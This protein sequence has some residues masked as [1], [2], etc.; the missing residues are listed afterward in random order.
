MTNENHT[1]ISLSYIQFA[2]ILK[3]CS[4]PIKKLDPS[5]SI[6]RPCKSPKLN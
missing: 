6:S 1:N 2:I 4:F 5:N 3:N